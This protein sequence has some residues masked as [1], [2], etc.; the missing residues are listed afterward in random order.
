MVGISRTN[1]SC[2]RTRRFRT[3]L[4][5]TVHDTRSDPTE[6]KSSHKTSHLKTMGGQ[7]FQT[8][9]GVAFSI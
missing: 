5:L 9:S 1:R 8:V 7:L 6:L 4:T 2:F 3:L